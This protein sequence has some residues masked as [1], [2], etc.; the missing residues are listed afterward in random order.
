MKAIV[1]G[2]GT[3]GLGAVHTL[4]VEHDHWWYVTG[5]V[6][7]ARQDNPRLFKDYLIYRG[8]ISEAMDPFLWFRILGALVTGKVAA[9]AVYDRPKA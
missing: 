9:L 1:V 6:S 8:T 2:A 3:A 7:I 5:A 4:K